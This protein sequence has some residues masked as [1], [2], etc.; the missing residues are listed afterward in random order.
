MYPIEIQTIVNGE[1]QS[2]VLMPPRA[3]LELRTRR[4]LCRGLMS[5]WEICPPWHKLEVVEALS[6][7]GW[8]RL[9]VITETSH[10]IGSR[11]RITTIP[12]FRKIC[13]E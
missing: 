11:C 8:E 12:L 13:I 6:A 2:A 10:S 3:E 9:L 5:S 1:V 4:R 7:W